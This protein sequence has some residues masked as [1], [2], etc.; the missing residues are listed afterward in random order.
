MPKPI[1]RPRTSSRRAPPLHPLA[2]DILIPLPVCLGEIL[3]GMPMLCDRVLA[4]II[5]NSGI[6]VKE[7]MLHFPKSSRTVITDRI[8]K[9]RRAGTIERC[10]YA[11]YGVPLVKPTLRQLT[12][13]G[14]PGNTGSG[15]IAPISVA[16]LMA[17]L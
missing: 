1:A 13:S 3:S 17:G 14:P 7:L 10:G 16:R 11:A 5:D 15:F 2:G 4:C 12:E 6:S 8:R 9:M